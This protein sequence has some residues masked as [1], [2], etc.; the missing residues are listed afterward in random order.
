MIVK[1]FGKAVS[2]RLG[3]AL[4][5]RIAFRTPLRHLHDLDGTRY[6]GRWA[7]INEDTLASRIL[8]TLTGYASVRLHHITRADHDRDF[9]NHPF[10]YRTFIVAG[11]YAE[12]FRFGPGYTEFP[13]FDVLGPGDSGTGGAH[14]YHRIAEVSSG[15]V[16]TLFFMTRNRDD[17][18]FSVNG[19]HVPSVR[20]LLR[21]GYQNGGKRP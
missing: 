2:S 12:S 3:S 17:W 7:I 18:G 20:Y 13:F 4:L 15:G 16:W 21:K 10:A 1:L 19:E 9:H 8:E 11:G 14:I 6:M 5:K